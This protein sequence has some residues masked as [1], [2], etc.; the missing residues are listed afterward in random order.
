MIVLKE[1]AKP[2]YPSGKITYNRTAARRSLTEL[3]VRTVTSRR[4]GLESAVRVTI[5]P[6]GPVDGGTGITVCGGR[7]E[8]VWLESRYLRLGKGG[9]G[10]PLYGR[11]GSDEKWN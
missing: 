11:T 2:T 5:V 9:D 6:A 3:D 7:K 4:N 10:L 1:G 8:S